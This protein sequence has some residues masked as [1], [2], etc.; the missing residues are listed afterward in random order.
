MPEAVPP[1]FDRP[2]AALAL[3]LATCTTVLATLL[4]T[5]RT[6]GADTVFWARGATNG[7]QLADWPI[8]TT[9]LAGIAACA[10]A[11][12]R[13]TTTARVAAILAGAVLSLLALT[14]LK[15]DGP[16]S[17]T[18]L[19]ALDPD[20]GLGVNTGDLPVLCAWVVGGAACMLLARHRRG[21]P[22]GGT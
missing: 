10:T 15:G 11:T 12:L 3:I 4:A 5:G 17:G 1:R 6:P 22:H 20:L 9:W 21:R 2:R 7:I 8:A 16:D 13:R 18:T 19:V 14:L